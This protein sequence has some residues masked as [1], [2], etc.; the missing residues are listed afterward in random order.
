MTRGSQTTE[1]LVRTD[2][3][4]NFG[5]Y[6]FGYFRVESNIIMRHHELPY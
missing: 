6:I 1:G 2:D 5:R 4:Y 3:V